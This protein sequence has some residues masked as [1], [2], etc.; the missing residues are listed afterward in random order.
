M[1]RSAVARPEPD[2][3]FTLIELVVCLALLAVIAAIA[4]PR[5]GGERAETLERRAA[6]IAADLGR[7][8]QEAMQAGGARQLAAEAVAATLP[9]PFRL[10]AA[11]PERIVFFPN[12]TANG[13]SWRL[14]AY[15]RT[16]TLDVDWLTGRVAVDG[17]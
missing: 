2:A 12:G 17:P 11:L 8:R 13:A 6:A 7:L 5:L 1:P 15:G 14:E 3:G 9:D 16:M 4:V 10:T